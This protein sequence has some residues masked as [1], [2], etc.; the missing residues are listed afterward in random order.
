M[1][2]EKVLLEL[3]G[4]AFTGQVCLGS[5]CSRL[6]LHLCNESNI[7][8]DTQPPLTVAIKVLFGNNTAELSEFK[9]EL[10]V[11]C[12]IVHP[13]VVKLIGIS[14]QPS[15]SMVYLSIIIF[16]NAAIRYFF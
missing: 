11:L 8:L 7:L 12:N 4:R 2:L 5:N 1:S 10:N 16:A 15:L 6:Y 13:N 3:F 9:K 14:L